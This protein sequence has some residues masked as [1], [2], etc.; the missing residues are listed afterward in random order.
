[1]VEVRHRPLQCRQEE[2][3]SGRA[4]APG[5]GRSLLGLPFYLVPC[6]FPELAAERSPEAAFLFH[7]FQSILE[8]IPRSRAA[9]SKLTDST[10][11]TLPSK[12]WRKKGCPS[13]F[14]V[15]GP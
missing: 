2:Y 9:F 8:S 12:C 1:M 10:N 6:C 3:R 7:R 4:A 13:R 14:C 15:E 5:F 11:A